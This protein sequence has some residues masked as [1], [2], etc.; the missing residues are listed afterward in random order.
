MARPDDNGES[1]WVIGEGRTTGDS[2]GLIL[3]NSGYHVSVV[4]NVHE[5]LTEMQ[6]GGFDLVI[7]DIKAPTGDKLEI[8]CQ[9]KQHDADIVVILTTDYPVLETVIKAIRYNAYLIKPLEKT[10]EVLAIVGEE[11][12]RRQSFLADRHGGLSP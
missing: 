5:A 2:L 8:L 7:A 4:Y 1:I 12:R 3:R 10:D 9:I 11:L 6:T